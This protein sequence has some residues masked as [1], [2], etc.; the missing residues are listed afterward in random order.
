MGKSDRAFAFG[1]LGLAVGLGVPSEG[2]IT[3]VLA[4]LAILLVVTAFNRMRSGIRRARLG[5]LGTSRK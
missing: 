1:A 3:I 4:A 5:A 2:W